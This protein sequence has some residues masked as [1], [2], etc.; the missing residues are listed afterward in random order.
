VLVADLQGRRIGYGHHGQRK[1]CFWQRKA[2][3]MA[4]RSSISIPDFVHRNPIPNACRVGNL[5]MSGVIN[6]VDPATGRVAPTLAAQCTFMFAHMR[7]IVEAAGGSTDDIVKVTVWLKDRSQREALNEA[8]VAMFPDESARP[9]RHS[10][11]AALE[12]DVLIQCDFTAWL[13]A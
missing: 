5:V 3:I 9:A 1:A 8:W 11:Q 4:R 12:G 13:G 7:K 2:N 10:M 6:G